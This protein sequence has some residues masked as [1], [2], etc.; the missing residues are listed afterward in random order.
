M[1]SAMVDIFGNLLVT[2]PLEKNETEMPSPEQL[3][4]KILVKHKKLPDGADE[5]SFLIT[6]D[7]GKN[8]YRRKWPVTVKPQ[9]ML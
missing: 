2:H 4:R 1:A 9:C 6:N 8:L 7:D 5:G 3:K